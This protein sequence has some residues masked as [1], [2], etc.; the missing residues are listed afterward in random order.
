[1]SSPN[2]TERST[3][4]AWGVLLLSSLAY[5]GLVNEADND[6]WGHLFV[7]KEILLHG[8]VPRVDP[9]SYTVAGQP[10]VNHEWLTQTVMAGLYEAGGSAALVLSKIGLLLV[11]F[12]FTW[13]GMVRRA[14][15]GIDKP[16]GGEWRSAWVWGLV[17]VLTLSVLARGLAIRPQLVSYSALAV[18]LAIL[19]AASRGHRRWLWW[20][21]PLFL[22]WA[23][24]HGAFVLGLGVLGVF[25]AWRVVTCGD[26]P[27]DHGLL[28]LVCGLASLLNLYGPKL[29]L[30]VWDELSR[31]HP[32]SEWQAVGLQAEHLPFLLMLALFVV[33]LPFRSEWR[34]AGWRVLL[35]L[36]M[37]VFAL[38]Q[39]RHTPVFALVAALPLAEQTEALFGS[40]LASRLALRASVRNAVLAGVIGLALVQGLLTGMRLWRDG[41]KIVFDPEDYPTGAVAA[42][43]S[44]A[45][46]GNLAVP[47]DWGAYVLWHLGPRVR[48]S[49]DGRFATVYPSGFVDTN[50]EFFAAGRGWRKLIDDYPT[51]AVLAPA[52]TNCPVQNEPG[53]RRVYADRVSVLFVRAGY[54]DAFRVSP[55]PPS[56]GIFP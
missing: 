38:R 2:F 39:Q 31:P 52:S 20:L 33:T 16:G 27:R 49:I 53:W 13:L 30:Y 1:V 36:V 35:A 29:A 40:P 37:G 15:G 28:V 3:V 56:K 19:D 34:I 46:V 5:F 25:T 55:A 8:S 50:F 17:G 7:G 24:F 18:E 23:N 6:L 14:A 9:Y 12:G 44:G 41:L 54:E 43:E 21:P 10:W 45:A 51:Q 26:S 4:V 22:L 32:I 47:L 48:P 11:M 42:L